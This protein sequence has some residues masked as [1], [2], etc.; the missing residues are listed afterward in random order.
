MELR[1]SGTQELRNSGTQ[2]LRNSGTQEL[3]NSGT[4][5]K[6][7]NKKTAIQLSWHPDRYERGEARLFHHFL[8]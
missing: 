6:T 4:Q 3:R 2:E 7:G 5:E 1:N 8:S